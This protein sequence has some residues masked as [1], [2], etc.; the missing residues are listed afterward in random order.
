M[1]KKIAILQSN[2]IPWK[3]YFD[4]I[5]MVDEFI[6]Y[7]TVQYTKNDWR[8]RNIIKTK[9]GL[10]WLTVPV[11]FRNSSQKICETK[12]L[13]SIWRIK[14]WK[15]LNQY[16]SK[17][18][19]FSFYKDIFHEV[20][21]NGDETRLSVINCSFIKTINSILGIDTKISLATEYQCDGDRCE[22]L[23]SLCKKAGAS[24]YLSGPAAKGYLDESLFKA[25][26]IQVEWMD[27]SAY[28]EYE[29][30]YP[31]FV[32]GVTILDLIFH[33]GPKAIEHLKSFRG[34]VDD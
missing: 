31:P 24:T 21:C 2:Y 3:G 12:T 6:L 20:Y 32:H 27:Y 13:N 17:A 5:N 29:Q 26:H 33:Q 22:R 16:Y 18:K 7:D 19:Y 11:V 1:A 10:Q 30:F 23:V 8:N 15:T 25:E 14:H 34:G 4:I 9:N 28:P